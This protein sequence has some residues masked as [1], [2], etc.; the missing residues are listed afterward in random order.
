MGAIGFEGLD[1]AELMAGPAAALAAIGLEPAQASK[2]A[3]RAEDAA[4]TETLRTAV[5]DALAHEFKTP[6]ATVL[7]A[8]GGLREAGP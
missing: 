8:A 6:L 5:L 7:T 2:S 3:T 1:H 4:R